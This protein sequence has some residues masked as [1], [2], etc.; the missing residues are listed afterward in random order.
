MVLT[1]K[2]ILLIANLR[3]NCRQSLKTISKATK[4]PISTIYDKLR[5][6]EKGVIKRYT[7]IINYQKL[8][9]NI[10]AQVLLKVKNEKRQEFQDFIMKQMSVNNVYKV[11]NGYDFMVDFIF[12]E[13]TE[14]EKFLEEIDDR[15]I[16]ERKHVSYVIN[17]LKTEG[18]M[19][20]PERYFN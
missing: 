19:D 16:I 6:Y 2:E 17:E 5:V 15:F 13:F 9:Y 10:R 14:S 3:K 7:S 1:P 4:I 11:N 20:N 8:G 18:F 12:K